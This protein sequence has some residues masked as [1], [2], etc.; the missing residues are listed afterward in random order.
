MRWRT[1]AGAALALTGLV[2]VSGAVVERLVTAQVRRAA[3]TTLT[4]QAADRALLLT[5]G[6]DPSSLVTVVGEEVLAVV[7]GPDGAVLAATGTPDAA[8]LTV[9]GPGLHTIDIVVDEDGEDD[10]QEDEGDNGHTLDGEDDEDGHRERIRVAVAVAADGTR[11]VV[12]NEGEEARTTIAAV[13][14]VLAVGGPLMA[15]AGALVAWLVT[16]RALAPVHRLR[17]DLAAVTDGGGRVTEPSTGDEI[18][19][20]ARTTNA[21]LADLERQSEARRRFVSD[22]SHE[23]KSPIANARILVE[24]GSDL[25][26]ETL[27]ATLEA[28]LDRLQSLV[29]DL[30]YLARTD[31]AVPVSPIPFDLDDVVFDEAERATT[32]A[33]VDIDASGVQPARVVADRPEVARAVRN[34]LENAVR[35]ARTRVDLAVVPDEAWWWVEVSDDGPGIPIEERDRVFERFTRLDGDRGRSEGGTGLGLSIVAAI[36]GRNGGGV[37]VDEAPGGGARFRL[38]LPVAR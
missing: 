26:P 30:L 23:L 6:A 27:R 1:S 35:H 38:R 29:D 36:A 31:E 8:G 14:T 13:R 16:G 10:G 4:E 25:P 12:G 15:A 20:L 19:A 21:V 22:A 33:S 5:G 34:L 24:T 28:E 7:L 11:I 37:L 3:D 2:L 32:R 9:L 18:E 17:S